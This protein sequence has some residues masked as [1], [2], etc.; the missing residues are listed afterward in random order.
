MKIK[1][2]QLERYFAKHEFSAKYLLSSSD[3]DGYALNYIL[4]VA[5]KNELKLWE[6]LTM[7]YTESEGHTL[8]RE[9]I[10]QYYKNQTIENV[11]VAS[12]GELNFVAMNVLLQSTDHVISVS[13]SYQSLYEV[14]NSLKCELSY[15]EP[16]EENWKFDVNDL[17]GLIKKNTKL[18]IIP[19]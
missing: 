16:N 11:V 15:W 1:D 4:D 18:R 13:P 2:F 12:P 19:N 8:L 9:A 10:L 14:V 7:G 5:S 3:C 17:K 6:S